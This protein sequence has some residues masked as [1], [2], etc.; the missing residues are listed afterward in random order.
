MGRERDHIGTLQG[1]FPSE[2]PQGYP[3]LNEETFFFTPQNTRILY[4]NFEYFNQSD[5]E[6]LFHH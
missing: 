4:K 2:R 1:R 5:K 6:T 3:D